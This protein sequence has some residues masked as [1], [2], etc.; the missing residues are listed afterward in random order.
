MASNSHRHR[1]ALA[2]NWYPKPLVALWIV[3][4]F[5]GLI[6][7]TRCT[8]EKPCGT[9][10]VKEGPADSNRQK[11]K[12]RRPSS[13]PKR[14][15]SDTG[16]RSSSPTAERRSR[17]PAAKAPPAEAES[18]ENNRLEISEKIRSRKATPKPLKQ[19]KEKDSK[20][21]SKSRTKSKSPKKMSRGNTLFKR[22]DE[23]NYAKI[24]LPSDLSAASKPGSVT[25]SMIN[26][27][28]EKVHYSDKYYY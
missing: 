14:G 27:N 13:S 10:A 28:Q 7:L 23:G 2:G 12:R 25:R 21:K 20:K 18:E 6:C 24:L 3:T 15:A 1:Q 19:R 11:A 4:A 26:E 17:S 16:R 22:I 5:S 8:R 9:S